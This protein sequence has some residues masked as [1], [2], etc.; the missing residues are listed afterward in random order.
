MSERTF[1]VVSRDRS[2]TADPPSNQT[3]S[4]VAHGDADSYSS[5]QSDTI[6]AIMLKFTEHKKRVLALQ[7]ENDSLKLHIKQLEEQLERAKE[8]PVSSSSQFS[9]RC[10]VTAE[11]EREQHE[12]LVNS[13]RA[14]LEVEIERRIEAEMVQAADRAELLQ[15]Y[16]MHGLVEAITTTASTPA[17]VDVSVPLVNAFVTV[18]NED[19]PL[20]LQDVTSNHPKVVEGGYSAHS[21]AEMTVE[22]VNQTVAVVPPAVH[23]SSIRMPK[24]CTAVRRSKSNRRIARG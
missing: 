11:D 19:E 13:L 22:I 8:S 18:D 15:C 12:M 21:A 20:H 2:A 7:K 3:T 16:S 24:R 1:C 10:S 4:S 9:D 17:S 5:E 6:Y 23:P 14:A